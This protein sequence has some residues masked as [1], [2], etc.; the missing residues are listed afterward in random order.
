M[1]FWS[2]KKESLLQ[3]LVEISF[4]AV[5]T[6]IVIVF[7]AQFLISMVDKQIETASKRDALSTF[8]NERLG[9]LTTQFSDGFLELKCVQSVRSAETETCRSNI[10]MFLTE[11]DEIYLELRVHYPKIPFSA[12]LNLKSK[13]EEMR[14]TGAQISQGEI[15]GFAM[16]FGEALDEM[17]MNFQ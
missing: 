17:A 11:L 13:A 14:E 12:L 7:F 4:K 15:D 5:L 3:N 10:A 2:G 1:S 9:K 16:T 8:K 6:G